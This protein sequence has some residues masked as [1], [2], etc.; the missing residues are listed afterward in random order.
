MFNNLN[1][2]G[3]VNQNSIYVPSHPS[4]NDCHQENKQK[5]VRI[6]GNWKP[7]TFLVKIQT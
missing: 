6:F 4:Q 1:Y 2:T 3:N 5:L 7:Y